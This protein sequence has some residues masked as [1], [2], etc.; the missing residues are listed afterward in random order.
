MSAVSFT[1]RARLRWAA[2]VV[3][4]AG[5]ALTPATAAAVTPGFGGL[6]R[7]SCIQDTDGTAC[8]GVGGSA[9]GLNGAIGVA[10]SGDGRNVYV[11][12]RFSDAIAVFTRYGTTG[13]LTPG[14]CIQETGG[15]DCGGAGGNAAGLDGASGVAVSGDGRHVYV[16]SD[17][18][19]A[20][21]VF[22]HDAL[23][24][25]LTKGGC[26]QDEG[27]GDCGSGG[28]DM[29]AGLDGATGVAVSGD[30]KTVYVA[31]S[32]AD[33]IGAFTRDATSGGLSPGGCIE[34]TGGTECQSVGGNASGL[35]GASAVAVS[36]DG[37]NVYV[38]S[39]VSDAIAVFQRTTSGGLI[40]GGCIQNTGG[41]DC[42]GGAAGLDGA[43]GVAVSGDGRNVYVASRFSGAIA[44]FRRDTTT[45]G[46]TP[47][48]CIQNTGGP[49]CSRNATGLGGASGVA[50]S[51]DGRNVYVASRFSG[52][53]AVFRRNATTGGL[54]PGGCIQN[55]PLTACSGLGGNAPGLGGAS[56]VATSADGKN[57]YVASQVSDAIAVFG[58]DAVAPVLTKLSV[59]P[60]KWAVGKGTTFT[61][62]LSER[63][64]VVFTIER[65]L[66]GRR[67][68]GRC[69]QR[70]PANRGKPP[71]TR[72]K[73]FGRFE[74]Q[75]GAGENTRRF[76]GRIGNKSLAP[77]NYRATLVASDVVGLRSAPKRVGF[78]IVSR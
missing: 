29:A 51:E 54:T 9:A 53:I 3:V 42:S 5:L 20:I 36:G 60:A 23:T 62:S 30:G 32:F 24:D 56:G 16:A 33:T 75:G 50:V 18:S 19:D 34:N 69:V 59:Q 65:K 47:G 2:Y 12:S 7:G 4:G 52:A 40:P 22:R 71:C 17:S 58:R 70:R 43:S 21:A 64:R 49:A 45:G 27:R 61:Y 14:G 10:T 11:A 68:A 35:D 55:P 77:G 25:G 78:T 66:P 8:S 38:A 6:I 13:A 26:I 74:Q 41:T 46:L 1:R 31:S 28:G 63:A 67:V 72:F 37:K 39:Y 15:T 73:L 48:G 44:V 76:S 57:V